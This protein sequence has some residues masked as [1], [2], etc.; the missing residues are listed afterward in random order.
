MGR[1]SVLL[2]VF[3]RKEKTLRALEA[4]FSQKLPAG[5]ELSVFLVD[6]GSTD[7][8]YESVARQFPQ[9]NLLR[10]TGHLFWCGGMRLAFTEAMKSHCDYYL[11]LNDDTTLFPHALTELLQIS[12]SVGPRAIVVASSQD[13]DTGQL[14]YGGVERL[15]RWKPLRFSRVMPVE[16][17]IPVETMNGNCV[18]IPQTVAEKIGNLD[19]HFTHGIGDF[20]YGLRARRLGFEVILAPG[21]LA[22][23][24]RNPPAV[25]DRSLRTRWKK[26][27]SP[28]GL[29]PKEWAIFARRYAG[30]FWFIYWIPFYVKKLI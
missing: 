22:Y 14:T 23:C 5:M 26:M 16:K 10:G 6:D 24:R 17:P 13:P 30:A 7:G 21:Y 29:P 27:L 12:T 11:W 1:I 9:V 8:T 2:T 28:H 3:N 19:P 20:D 4:L 18:L 25:K 15:N